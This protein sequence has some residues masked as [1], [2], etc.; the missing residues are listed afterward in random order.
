MVNVPTKGLGD[1]GDGDDEGGDGEGGAEVDEEE[2]PHGEDGVAGAAA[3]FSSSSRPAIWGQA[4]NDKRF[5]G[6]H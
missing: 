4:K 2:P 6:C 3:G 5:A 1:D